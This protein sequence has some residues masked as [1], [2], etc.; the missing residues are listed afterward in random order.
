MLSISIAASAMMVQDPEVIYIRRFLS[1][2]GFQQTHPPCAYEDNRTC[3]A[4]SEGSVGGSD[5]ANLKHIDLGEHF[6]HNAV[7]QGFLKLN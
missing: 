1:N 3:V 5:R 2:L 6:V 4:W 7:G